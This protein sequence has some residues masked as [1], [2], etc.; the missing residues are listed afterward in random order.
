MKTRMNDEINT[1][2]ARDARR[3]EA[4]P[5]ILAIE[6]AQHQRYLQPEELVSHDELEEVV[7]G[8]LGLELA[9]SN[10][11]LFDEINELMVNWQWLWL[12]YDGGMQNFYARPEKQRANLVVLSGTQFVLQADQ[13]F[14]DD[15]SEIS[16]ILWESDLVASILT[17]NES[18]TSPQAVEMLSD[19]V[20]FKAFSE[21]HLI[22]PLEVEGNY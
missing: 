12:T 11:G 21:V 10:L 16:H 19:E 18:C 4:V 14:P 13:V 9:E 2:E 5:I 17:K 15:I 1:P 7:R 22:N 6:L 8:I 3:L 20:L